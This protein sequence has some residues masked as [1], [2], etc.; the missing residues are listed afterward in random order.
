M[1]SGTRTK[2]KPQKAR[3]RPSQHEKDGTPRTGG[4]GVGGGP[5]D[6]PTTL[7]KISIHN[8]V[9]SVLRAT[10]LHAKIHFAIAASPIRLVVNGAVIGYVGARDEKK[11]REHNPS[12]GSLIQKSDGKKTGVVGFRSNK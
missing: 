2:R 4:V 8:A 5:G 7:I 10:P 9:E 6:E 12:I 11:V 3:P 1:G